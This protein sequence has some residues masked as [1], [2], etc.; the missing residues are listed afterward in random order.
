[1]TTAIGDATARTSAALISGDLGGKTLYAGLYKSS[2]TIG[3]TGNLTLD[4][5]SHP[6]AVFIFQIANTLSSAVSSQVILA[7]GAEAS[8]IYWQV[9]TNCSLGNYSIFKGTIMTGTATTIGTGVALDGR[10]LAKSEVTMQGDDI[11]V[12]TP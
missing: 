8:N 4:A 6:N 9:G 3:I 12:P 7:N 1:L 2:G 5:Q 11:A 10:A